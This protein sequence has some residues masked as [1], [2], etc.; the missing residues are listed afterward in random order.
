[1]GN[2]EVVVTYYV[3]YVSAQKGKKKKCAGECNERIEIDNRLNRYF[4]NNDYISATVV[5]K[6]K[7]GQYLEYIIYNK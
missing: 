3:L 1:M 2:R 6:H 7:D 5:C 4:E